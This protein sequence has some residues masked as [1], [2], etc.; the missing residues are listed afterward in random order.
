MKT[1]LLSKTFIAASVLLLVPSCTSKAESKPSEEQSSSESVFI[2]PNLVAFPSAFS[3][4]QKL[5]QQYSVALEYEKGG[6]KENLNFVRYNEYVKFVDTSESN[7]RDLFIKNSPEGSLFY[8][9]DE[10]GLFSSFVC[11]ELNQEELYR[12]AY[13]SCFAGQSFR[14][15]LNRETT[16]LGR[17]CMEYCNE[18][19]WES[20]SK[21]SLI[22]DKET[23][24]ILHLDIDHL[25]DSRT[26]AEKPVDFK[27]EVKELLLGNATKNKI[28]EDINKVAATVL[29][30]AMIESFGFA[31]ELTTPQLPIATCSTKWSNNKM[32]EYN[33]EYKDRVNS[34]NDTYINQFETFTNCLYN[35]GFDKDYSGDELVVKNYTDLI[36]DATIDYDSDI[37]YRAY[38]KK[39]TD[40][41]LVNSQET[42]KGKDAS[43]K[44]QLSCVTR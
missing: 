6:K 28:E 26:Q 11:E 20:A 44:F 29:N 18:E 17:N 38:A 30:S 1:R 21:G 41:Y 10:E 2:D 33:I 5:G 23:N 4:D 37:S 35:L 9:K 14:F 7:G 39:G 15:S 32:V 40:I 12:Q 8:S 25:V 22:V 16:F 42:V 36:V 19:S 3:I 13:V 31:G 24:F 27:F 34:G 43:I